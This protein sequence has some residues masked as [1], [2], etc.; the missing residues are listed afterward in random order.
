M[1]VARAR[2]PGCAAG[3]LEASALSRR[4]I[5][6]VS[7]RRLGAAREARDKALCP[8]NRTQPQP[9]TGTSVLS[10]PA[11]LFM[12]WPALVLPFLPA[13]D[14]QWLSQQFNR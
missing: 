4:T 7:C 3:P 6:P 12:R 1:R 14:G 9:R 2:G 10:T 11:V 5:V 13:Q 8:L